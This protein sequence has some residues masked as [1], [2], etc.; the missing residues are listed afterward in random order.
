MNFYYWS[1]LSSQCG[2]PLKYAFYLSDLILLNALASLPLST[3]VALLINAAI[4]G[5][6]Q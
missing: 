1:C 5:T 3:G 4:P 6:F 2:Q